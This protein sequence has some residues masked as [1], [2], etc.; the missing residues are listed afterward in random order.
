M[1]VP[2]GSA[3]ANKTVEEAGLRNLPG[4]FLIEIE[5]G[6]EAIAAVGPS[7]VLHENDRLVFAGVVEAI[8]ELQNLRG[9]LPATDQVFKLDA[10]R[11]H[12]P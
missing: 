5:R 7:Q 8:K 1:L 6:D 11:H 3:L 2:L 12:E 9:L 4:C 10:P